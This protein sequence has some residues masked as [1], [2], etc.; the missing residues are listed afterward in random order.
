M[1]RHGFDW[2]P[3]KAAINLRDHHVAF[4]NAIEVFNDDRA[5]VEDDPDPDEE[6]FRIVGM[7]RTGVVLVVVYTERDYETIRI[8]SARK[9]KKHEIRRAYGQG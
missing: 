8:I 5:I 2:D 6:R 9:A 1:R 7:S 4:E 3:V